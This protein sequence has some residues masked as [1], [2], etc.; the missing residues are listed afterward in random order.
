MLL[1]STTAPVRRR[2][3][4]SSSRKKR[5]D[6][7]QTLSPGAVRR[8]LELLRREQAASQSFYGSTVTPEAGG[9]PRGEGRAGGTGSVSTPPFLQLFFAE[10]ST[11]LLSTV[12][13]SRW[14]PEL[15][16][17]VRRPA[18]T[19]HRKQPNAY[20][21]SSHQLFLFDFDLIF[22]SGLNNLPV[23][24]AFQNFALTQQ[25]DRSVCRTIVLR[26]VD[27]RPELLRWLC[28][29]PRLRRVEFNNCRGD[30]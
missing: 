19:N 15:T 20:H 11:D 24:L 27:I 10:L 14:G 29:F 23:H 5:R 13:L 12:D 17:T 3:P 1:F 8:E 7:A 6:A 25:I 16:P 4:F 9:R 2:E 26:D 18:I 22:D 21:S 28:T 30:P